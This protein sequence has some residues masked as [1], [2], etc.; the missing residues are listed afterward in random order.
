MLR[1]LA[2]RSRSCCVTLAVIFFLG[3]Y[4]L[5][6]P[7]VFSLARGPGV[8]RACEVELHPCRL[9]DVRPPGGGSRTSSSVVRSSRVTIQSGD[10]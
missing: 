3:R 8:V 5:I 2:C 6:N 9:F 10:P 1:L 7:L 4:C